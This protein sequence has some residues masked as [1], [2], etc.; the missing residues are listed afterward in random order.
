MT[1]IITEKV[2]MTHIHQVSSGR[3]PAMSVQDPLATFLRGHLQT[4][5][6]QLGA[7]QPPQGRV[8]KFLLNRLVE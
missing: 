6:G 1:M 8:Q 3:L 5:E 7:Q 4:D 2:T